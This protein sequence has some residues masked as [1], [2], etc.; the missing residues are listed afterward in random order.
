[1]DDG[2]SDTDRLEP[3]STP[4]Q[5]D[6]GWSIPMLPTPQSRRPSH[7]YQTVS[8]SDPGQHQAQYALVDEYYQRHHDLSRRNSIVHGNQTLEQHHDVTVTHHSPHMPQHPIYMAEHP[9]QGIAVMNSNAI[10]RT[11]QVHQVKRP[12]DDVSCLAHD[13]HIPTENHPGDLSASSRGSFTNEEGLY[14]EQVPHSGTHHLHNA[15]PIGHHHHQVLPYNNQVSQLVDRPQQQ[16]PV[17]LQPSPMRNTQEHFQQMAQPVT[18]C[19]YQ[20]PIEVTT[21]GQMPVFSGLYN[22]YIE[23]KLDYKLE[24][25]DPSIQLPSARLAML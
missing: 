13:I 19:D 20:S 11:Y 17:P 1:M 21:I 10:P 7:V 24:F 15:P 25:D 12:R 22:L 14:L 4:D 3:P 23:P 18:W 6:M 5:V 2:D 16:M 9:D 8:M